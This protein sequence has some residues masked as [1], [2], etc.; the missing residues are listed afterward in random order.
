MLQMLMD[1]ALPM[2]AWQDAWAAQL[3]LLEAAVT[4]C[5]GIV[6]RCVATLQCGS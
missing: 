6:A 3:Q 4:V 5:S 1:L 2:A